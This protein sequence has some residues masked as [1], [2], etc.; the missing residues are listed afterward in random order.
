MNLRDKKTLVVYALSILLGLGLGIIA[1]SSGQD[2]SSFLNSY[3]LGNVIL[4]GIL[5]LAGTGGLT[6]LRVGG[7]SRNSH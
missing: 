4:F 3:A 5:I 6:F 1:S 7:I 2:L